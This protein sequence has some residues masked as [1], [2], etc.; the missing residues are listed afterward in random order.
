MEVPS[1]PIIQLNCEL[2]AVQLGE[3]STTKLFVSTWAPCGLILETHFIIIF[4]HLSH[5][6]SQTSSHGLSVPSGYGSCHSAVSNQPVQPLIGMP[7]TVEWLQGLANASNDMSR[8]SSPL[9]CVGANYQ[10]SDSP[11]PT[12]T[13]SEFGQMTGLQN[14]PNLTPG[15]SIDMVCKYH[16]IMDNLMHYAKFLTMEKSLLAM[17]K[18]YKWMLHILRYLGLKDNNML[19]TPL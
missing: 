11:V 10:I 16:A 14:V 7:V 13:D 1:H 9:P 18:N 12:I 19:F 4:S 17:V 3:S 6:N 15:T 8:I 5:D 2:L